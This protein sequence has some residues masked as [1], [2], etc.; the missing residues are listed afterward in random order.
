M[1]V[2]VLAFSSCMEGYQVLG[3]Y[4]SEDK[5]QKAW[6]VFLK[7]WKDDGYEPDWDDETYIFESE[8]DVAA[9]YHDY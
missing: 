1:K 8:L 2:W 9:H 7:D 6:S 4:S 5:A 3:I